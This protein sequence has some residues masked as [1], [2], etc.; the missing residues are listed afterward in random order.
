MVTTGE[1]PGQGSI[2]FEV[3]INTYTLIYIYKRGINYTYPITQEIIL[4]SL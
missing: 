1:K 2:N 3:G 4:Y